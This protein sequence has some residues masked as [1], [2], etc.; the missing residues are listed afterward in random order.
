M[1]YS[2]H[3]SQI[4]RAHEKKI[5]A[6][7]LDQLLSNWFSKEDPFPIGQDV[8]SED[9]DLTWVCRQIANPSSSLDWGFRTVQVEVF[10][11]TGGIPLIQIELIDTRPKQAE[12]RQ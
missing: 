10:S 7:E 3:V 2:K 5:A 8:L 11:R 1:A 12:V 9:L 4:A 6:R